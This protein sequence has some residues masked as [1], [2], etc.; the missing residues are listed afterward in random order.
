VHL[1]LHL[2]DDSGFHGVP[3]NPCRATRPSMSEYQY[4]E[5]LA[6]DRPLNARQ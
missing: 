5:F 1:L 3:F 4:Y 2:G 6:L